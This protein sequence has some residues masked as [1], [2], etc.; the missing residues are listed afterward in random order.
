MAGIYTCS[1]N[2]GAG[3]PEFEKSYIRNI[4]YFLIIVLDTDNALVSEERAAR[5]GSSF[6]MR[7]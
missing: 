7:R 3:Y 1:V 4:V 6:F 5:T 2:F